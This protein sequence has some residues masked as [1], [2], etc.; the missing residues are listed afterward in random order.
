MF[1]SQPSCA[2]D[3]MWMAPVGVA[4]Y[5]EPAIEYLQSDAAD[6]D[7]EFCTYL[8]GGLVFHL[9]ESNDLENSVRVRIK[10]LADYIRSN[11]AKFRIEPDDPV[12]GY[13]DQIDAAGKSE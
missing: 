4:Y 7:W 13:L 3:F 5:L 10:E 12:P 6:G 2:E 1:E 9:T 11:S 8:P